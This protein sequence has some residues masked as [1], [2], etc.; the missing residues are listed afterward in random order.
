[1]VVESCDAS[2]GVC[3]KDASQTE[4][5]SHG[6][7]CPGCGLGVL[8]QLQDSATEVGAV[9]KLLK[10]KKEVIVNGIWGSGLRSADGRVC[11]SLYQP[12]GFFDLGRLLQS[13]LRRIRL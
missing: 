4:G 9:V 5:R 6:R 3:G 12:F 8:A 11:Q 2:L 1:M 10:G 13:E 7:E